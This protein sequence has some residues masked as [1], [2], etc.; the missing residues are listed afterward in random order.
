MSISGGSQ[1]TVLVAHPFAPSCTSSRESTPPAGPGVHGSCQSCSGSGK[2]YED[3]SMSM[4]VT[5]TCGEGDDNNNNNNNNSIKLRNSCRSCA[6]SKVRCNKGKP[7]CSRCAARGIDCQY[8]QSKR[9]GRVPGSSLRRL[10][11]NQPA[12]QP[13][14]SNN[15]ASQA[16][17]KANNESAPASFPPSPTFG[18]ED[19]TTDGSHHRTDSAFS[20]SSAG[21]LD[22]NFF[23]TP[24]GGDV[25]LN[26]SYAANAPVAPMGPISAPFIMED[27]VYSSLMDC[28]TNMVD[29][30]SWWFLEDKGSGLADPSIA[31][32]TKDSSSPPTSN[33]TSNP[34]STELSSLASSSLLSTVHLG[35]LLETTASSRVSGQ[36]RKQS[37]PPLLPEL[38]ES[39]RPGSNTT[40]PC[41]CMKQALDLL[42]NLSSAESSDLSP[43]LESYTQRVLT[44]NK[45]DIEANLAMLAC[46]ACSKDRFLL[47]ILLM[48]AAKILTRYVSAAASWGPRTPSNVSLEMSSAMHQERQATLA[49]DH[50]D[51]LMEMSRAW[52][53]FC[54]ML[55]A[56][57]G[58][59][60]A[61]SSCL[62]AVQRVLRE[63]HRVQRLI[64]QLSIRRKSLD[65]HEASMSSAA[66]LADISTT[67]PGQNNS[68]S[69]IGVRREPSYD[70]TTGATATTPFS[71][72][73]LEVVEVDV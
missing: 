62:E 1:D 18:L 30:N 71:S 55:P 7:T 44:E 14:T 23:T 11:P 65:E 73:A 67:H 15:S 20:T 34:A 17:T 68:G 58:G 25:D 9:P 39:G 54:M 50:A 22:A 48:I 28:N 59:G 46:R 16:A 35:D 56:P 2:T 52:G 70:S 19:C 5:P 10:Q 41:N 36:E 60:D 37:P 47:M 40:P 43:S 61:Q 51:R 32:Y 26:V 29:L 33:Y 66:G 49:S 8:L 3:R 64:S 53:G 6:N 13:R 57:R 21:T 4:N 12:D 38:A 27:I 31:D 72:S 63:L 45:Q 69:R 42:K 24:P